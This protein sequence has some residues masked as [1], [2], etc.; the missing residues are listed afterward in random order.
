MKSMNPLFLSVIF[1][2]LSGILTAQEAK[3]PFPQHTVYDKSTIMPANHSRAEMD[4]SVIEYYNL[5]KSSY[6][7]NNCSDQKQYYVWDNEDLEEN[8]TLRSIC[9][10]EGQGYGMLITVLMAGFDKDAKTIYD[11]MYKFYRAH[12]SKRSEYLMSWSILSGC[13]TNT[14]ND[15]QSS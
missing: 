11:G 14:K 8:E 10:S 15:N 4:K 12:P 3:R 6:V 1:F 9:V 7:R 13:I 2:I 5:W